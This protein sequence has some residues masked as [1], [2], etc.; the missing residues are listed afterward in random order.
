M[1]TSRMTFRERARKEPKRNLGLKLRTLFTLPRLLLLPGSPTS[2]TAAVT[3]SREE[4]L[5]TKEKLLIH[6]P[7]FS[8]ATLLVQEP[9]ISNPLKISSKQR[10]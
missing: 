1:L 10:F 5:G 9:Y 2:G 4:W 8:H 6:S 7:P 3:T